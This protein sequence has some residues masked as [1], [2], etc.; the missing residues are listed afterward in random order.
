MRSTW[1]F[2]PMEDPLSIAERIK[3]LARSSPAHVRTWLHG[4]FLRLHRATIFY[5]QRSLRRGLGCVISD[6]A[7]ACGGYS[8]RESFYSK[9]DS[10]AP[11]PATTVGFHKQKIP[12]GWRRVETKD[13][14]QDDEFFEALVEQAWNP[15]KNDREIDWKEGTL[16]WTAVRKPEIRRLARLARISFVECRRLLALT[17]IKEWKEKRKEKHWRRWTSLTFVRGSC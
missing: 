6:D 8:Q 14:S 2:S 16:R 3:C 4:H 15:T 7:I 11:L 13:S 5:F 17:T 1:W 12:E 10:E 9:L